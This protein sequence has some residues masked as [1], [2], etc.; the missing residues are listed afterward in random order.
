MKLL[1][2]KDHIQETIEFHGRIKK[3]ITAAVDWDNPYMLFWVLVA[4]KI[5]CTAKLLAYKR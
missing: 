4:T 2:K 5:C 1:A 3:K